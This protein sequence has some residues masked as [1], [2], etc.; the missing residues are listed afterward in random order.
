MSSVPPED[1]ASRSLNGRSR[2]PMRVIGARLKALRLERGLTLKEAAERSDLSRSFVSMVESGGT[3]IAVSRLMRLADTYGALLTELL[4]DVLDEPAAE[5][6]RGDHAS[7]FPTG[8]P[9]VAI[10]HLTSP[11]WGM[12]PFR[13]VIEP[14]AELE[15]MNRKS[16]E[17]VHCISGRARIVVEGR[18]DLLQ[19]GD[20]LY[21][22]GGV[23][24]TYGNAGD[25]QV[26]L[27]GGTLR[28]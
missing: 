3:E 16:D 12:Q 10:H 28:R 18:E 22:P 23:E 25:E 6:A 1:Q 14:G 4:V 5:V 26:V 21:V 8:T 9:G 24:H 19:P 27:I 15:P 13:M 11:S 17:F 2:E 7:S 20:T